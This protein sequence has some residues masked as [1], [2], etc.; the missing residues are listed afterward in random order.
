[1][2]E[3]SFIV[4]QITAPDLDRISP[5]C[6]DSRAVQLRILAQQEILGLAAWQGDNCIGSLHCYRVTLPD[7]DDTLF[8]GYG[9]DE[10][11]GW[12]LGW[13]LQAAKSLG[14]TFS[15]PVWGLSCFHVGFAGPA[16]QRADPAYFR[17]GIGR[18]LLE[19]AITWART[20]SYSAILA[21][22]GPDILPEYNIRM[23]CLPYTT[24]IKHGFTEFARDT[25]P[26]ELGWFTQQQGDPVMA[27]QVR[28]AL[29]DGVLLE[30]LG[31]RAMLLRL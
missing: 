1:M 12:P 19:A 10:P 11:R 25:A 14:L 9:C 28:R 13:P 31:A 21:H 6:W 18:A 7:Y 22:G 17:R 20:H 4:R 15:G 3:S 24:F 27:V 23:G 16:A 8:P 30:E 5:A 29:A 26:G 2:P